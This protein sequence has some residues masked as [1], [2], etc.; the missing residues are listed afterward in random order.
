MEMIAGS[1]ESGSARSANRGGGYG[2]RRGSNFGNQMGDNYSHEDELDVLE[3][4]YDSGSSDY[5][6]DNMGH[7]IK[8]NY[9]NPEERRAAKEK[10]IVQK[11]KTNIGQFC[12][13]NTI[14]DLLPYN[15]KLVVLNH[16]MTISQT[17]EAMIR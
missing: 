10:K 8:A 9:A 17:I 12:K 1:G 13:E 14:G 2:Q 5:E 11:M 16:E 6:I 15:Q 7:Q 3:A 4:N